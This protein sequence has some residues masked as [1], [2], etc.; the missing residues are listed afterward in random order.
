MFIPLKVKSWRIKE[1]AGDLCVELKNASGRIIG[2]ATFSLDEIVNI[3]KLDFNGYE[4]EFSNKQKY[5]ISASD[6]DKCYEVTTE[7]MNGF[8]R[9]S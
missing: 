1:G 3:I 2:R 7:E 5:I 8:E 9:N 6:I 4:V